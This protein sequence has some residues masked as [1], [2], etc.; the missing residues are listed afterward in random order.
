[1]LLV[2]PFLVQTKDTAR[3]KVSLAEHKGNTVIHAEILYSSS[4]LSCMQLQ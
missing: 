4:I 2:L 1:M 3:D